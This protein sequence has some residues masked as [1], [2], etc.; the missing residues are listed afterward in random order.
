MFAVSNERFEELAAEAI[1]GLPEEL[2]AAMDNVAIIVEDEARGRNLYGLYEGVPLTKRGFQSYSG[3][4]PDRI[5]LYQTTICHS[6][7]NEAD[8]R[9]MVRK[10]VVHEI[11]HHFG[12]SDPRLDELGWA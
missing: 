9:A 8:V 7:R 11:A 12:I 10:T 2:A 6:C 5:T 3:V 4:M 1:A